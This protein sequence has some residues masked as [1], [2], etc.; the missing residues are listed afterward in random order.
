M[1][2]STML[3]LHNLG[4]G[5]LR[6]GSDLSTLGPVVPFGQSD[7]EYF[8]PTPN[9]Q[10]WYRYNDDDLVIWG[11]GKSF[12]PRSIYLGVDAGK[13][14]VKISIFPEPA[15]TVKVEA[16][17]DEVYEQTGMSG[18]GGMRSILGSNGA[19]FKIWAPSDRKIMVTFFNPATNYLGPPVI[20]MFF[21]TV[22]EASR[23]QNLIYRSWR[24]LDTQ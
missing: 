23:R 21:A 16:I 19:D 14:L 4:V 12:N 22:T 18:D 13:Q 5:K 6:L 11:N 17:I 3:A 8:I 1:E 10:S 15:T 9:P 24:F 20:N 7:A 2:K